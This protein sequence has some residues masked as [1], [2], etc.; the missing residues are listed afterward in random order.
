MRHCRGSSFHR[1]V[2]YIGCIQPWFGS[3]WPLIRYCM[4]WPM[5]WDPHYFLFEM[6]WLHGSTKMNLNTIPFNTWR[7]GWI[8]KLLLSHSWCPLLQ[9][10]IGSVWLWFRPWHTCFRY[11]STELIIGQMYTRDTD[12]V[13]S[14]GS[15][16]SVSS[17]IEGCFLHQPSCFVCWQKKL[18]LRLWYYTLV[19]RITAAFG[20]IR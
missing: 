13:K 19:I 8:S 9:L 3:E 1:R 20:H 2:S 6:V 11:E 18:Y 10:K 5:A 7:I 16:S 15:A 17:D 4:K 12:W 14:R